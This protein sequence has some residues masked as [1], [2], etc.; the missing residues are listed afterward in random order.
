MLRS[1]RRRGAS[2][3]EFAL[4]IPFVTTTMAGV[5]DGCFYVSRSRSVGEAIRT[6]T[7]VGSMVDEDYPATGD[8]IKAGAILTVEDMLV[9][10]G[11]DKDDFKV[12]ATWEPDADELY[13]LEVKADVNHNAL[14]GD[15]SPFNRNIRYKM[16]V[17]TK[18]QPPPAA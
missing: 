18:E 3:L 7:R 11:V 5:I 6:G 9:A 15:W 13:W 14:F 10:N 17:V 1:L 2:A 16:I 8:D 12:T 4:C